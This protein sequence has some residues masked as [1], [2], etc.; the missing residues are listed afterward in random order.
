MLRYWKYGAALVAGALWMLGLVDQLGSFELTARYVVLSLGIV[1]V[2][3][4]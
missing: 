3:T 4:I 2:A 1:A